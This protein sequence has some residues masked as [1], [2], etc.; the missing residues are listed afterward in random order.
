MNINLSV[1]PIK[2]HTS[3]QR[4]LMQYLHLDFRGDDI[5]EVWVVSE[6]FTCYIEGADLHH[7][8]YLGVY[9]EEDFIEMVGGG[10]GMGM[11]RFY[12]LVDLH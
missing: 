4:K 2:E 12:K 9:G 5:L 8:E 7:K 10:D 1:L 6:T 11:H 3:T